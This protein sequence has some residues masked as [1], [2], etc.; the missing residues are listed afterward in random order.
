MLNILWLCFVD[1]V[2]NR[3]PMTK[4]GYKQTQTTKDNISPAVTMAT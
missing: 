2:Y 4:Y 1:T 3:F